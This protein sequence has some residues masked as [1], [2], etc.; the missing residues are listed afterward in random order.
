MA[1]TALVSSRYGIGSVLWPVLAWSI[2]AEVSIAD[3]VWEIV[4]QPVVNV[5]E[6]CLGVVFV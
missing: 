5:G 2:M 6:E 3:I 1:I 4:A